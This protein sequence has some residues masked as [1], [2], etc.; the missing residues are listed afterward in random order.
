VGDA[1]KIKEDFLVRAPIEEAWSFITDPHRVGSCI[2]GC[3][4]I[5]VLSDR[6]YRG[7]ISISVGPI[8]AKFNLVVDV[9]E[10]DA[11]H[12]IVSVTHG[13]EGSRASIISSNNELRLT[14]VGDGAV[15]IETEA[16]VSVSG[17]LGKFGLPIMKKKASQLAGQ[18]ALAM[19]EQLQTADAGSG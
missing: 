19:Q 1:V 2:P 14:D 10:L 4:A 6:S 13:E 15:K 18:F 9:K 17:R 12:R 3:E 5:E 11:P 8:S 16:D 7:R